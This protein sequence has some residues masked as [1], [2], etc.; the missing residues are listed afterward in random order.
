M[1]RPALSQTHRRRGDNKT[2]G[3]E[4]KPTRT[5]KTPIMKTLAASLIALT[6]L[7]SAA[8]AGF[9]PQDIRGFDGPARADITTFDGPAFGPS[10][11]RTFEGP[12]F[13]PADVK[14]F[15]GPARAEWAT[16]LADRK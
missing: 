10:D 4:P 13:G 6:A 14:S 16:D 5:G 9:G 2:A 12:A 11:V 8:S 15:E 1:D 3:H 7:A